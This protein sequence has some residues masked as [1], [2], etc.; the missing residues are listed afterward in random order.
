MSPEACC[1]RCH[2]CLTLSADPR[3]GSSAQL[4][5]A[6][7]PTRAARLL[8]LDKRVDPG[9]CERLYQSLEERK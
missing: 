4:A 6:E 5:N 7:V 1:R 8:E 9:F 3:R 2:S